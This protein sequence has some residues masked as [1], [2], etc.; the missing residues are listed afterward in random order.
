[1]A[2][3]EV[4]GERPAV[5]SCS[6]CGR[7]VC[8]RHLRRDPRSGRPICAVCEQALCMICG[9]RL[10]VGYCVSCGRL[11]CVECSVQ[12]DNVRRVCV[13]CYRRGVRPRPSPA[14]LRGAARLALR[15]VRPVAW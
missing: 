8:E 15:V 1:M 5:A 6:V 13:E 14:R 4:C 2:A 7:R 11:V 12:I 10:S 9:E 3:C